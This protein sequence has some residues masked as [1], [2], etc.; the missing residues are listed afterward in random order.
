MELQIDFSVPLEKIKWIG[1]KF[2]NLGIS[3][4]NQLFIFFSKFF[5][6][7]ASL[8]NCFNCGFELFKKLI[9]EN[10]SLEVK[11]FRSWYKSLNCPCTKWKF[12]ETI[13]GT[14]PSRWLRSR[15]VEKRFAIQEKVNKLRLHRNLLMTSQLWIFIRAS[16]AVHASDDI[17][18]TNFVTQ[19]NSTQN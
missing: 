8:W 11:A 2:H 5:L 3:K 14:R 13:L 15:D 12:P 4:E 1:K 9:C 17:T 19:V 10:C 18:N 16:W 6:L 7:Q